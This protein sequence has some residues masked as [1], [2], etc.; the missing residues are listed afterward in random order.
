[1]WEV[2]THSMAVRESLIR[3]ESE[4]R[5]DELMKREG[6]SRG[7]AGASANSRAVV[8]DGRVLCKPVRAAA[9]R[10]DEA[11]QA[12]EVVPR[13]PPEGWS[14]SD[15]L[16]HSPGRGMHN[17]RGFLHGLEENGGDRITTKRKENGPGRGRLVCARERVSKCTQG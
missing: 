16:S 4:A 3:G 15:S 6:G 9:A 14:L 17:F 11:G 2:V 1:M 13:L 5:F 7:R 12:R 8:V 10:P